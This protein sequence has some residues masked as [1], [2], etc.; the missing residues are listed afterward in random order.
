M[1]NQKKLLDK[2]PSKAFCALLVILGLL[3]GLINVFPHLSIK[4]EVE[5]RGY[6]YMP[7]QTE[8]MLT[9]EALWYVPMSKKIYENHGANNDF[10]FKQYRNSSTPVPLLPNYIYAF[11]FLFFRDIS[12][13]FLAG[14]FLFSGVLF[15]LFYFL[16]KMFF[17]NRTKALFFA[18]FVTIASVP[19]R[20]FLYV[21]TSMLNSG[22]T[23]ITSGSLASF[24]ANISY[25]ISTFSGFVLPV[26]RDLPV[27]LSLISLTDPLITY[28]IY[29]P[30]ITGLLYFFNK[31]DKK[32]AVISGILIGLSFQTYLYYAV[33]LSV[34][35]SLYLVYAIFKLEKKD[36]YKI[37]LLNGVIFLFFLFYAFSLYN[38]YSLP[39]AQD[40]ARRIGAEHGFQ[41]RWI[42]WKEYV[43]CAVFLFLNWLIFKNT[44]HKKY[45]FYLFVFL[46]MFICYNLQMIFGF[47][48]HPDHWSRAFSPLLFIFFLDVV[49]SWRY[50][51]KTPQMAFASDVLILVCTTLIFFTSVSNF[52]RFKDISGDKIAV[53]LNGFSFDGGI[54]QSY[55][56]IDNHPG[57][58]ISPSFLTTYYL[59]LYTKASPYLAS[60][61]NSLAGNYELEQRFLETFKVW[62]VP[63]SQLG[64]IL[65]PKDKKV[66][67]NKDISLNLYTNYY[68]D[69]SFNYS[70]VPGSGRDI[71][72]EKVEELLKRYE[73]IEIDP[74]KYKGYYLYYGPFER[75]LI[76]DFLPGQM[77]LEKVYHNEKIYI[78]KII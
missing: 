74:D 63:S 64:E 23:L 14:I 57:N 32:S 47:M 75:D 53:D 29:I 49:F 33:L 77:P 24:K 30:A 35:A 71:P 78:Y 7:V 19:I 36:L 58:Y 60:A 27:N 25:F 3:C 48:P 28:L 50:L 42:V 1:V 70:L 31:L 15:V 40:V 76:G 61:A 38:F 4:K 62:N 66:S 13:I 37:L 8:G 59:V 43:V 12:H 41:F 9:D 20:N 26:S 56:W 10:F 54:Y 16:G 72:A 69:Q 44:H 45:L 46:S 55:E 11:F 51:N 6:V 52:I 65:S 22:I 17:L 34:V 5:Q 73:D 67:L 2:L 21:L 68:S 39:Q 18:S